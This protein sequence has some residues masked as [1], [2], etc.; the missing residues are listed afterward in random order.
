[1]ERANISNSGYNHALQDAER[2]GVKDILLDFLR[3]A[4]PWV[5][6]K[7]RFAG[8]LVPGKLL[9]PSPLMIR[10][11]SLARRAA[12][13]NKISGLRSLAGFWEWFDDW[14]NPHSWIDGF[15]TADGSEAPKT[16]NGS[17]RPAD[18]SP[19]R[20]ERAAA[21]PVLPSAQTNTLNEASEGIEWSEPLS[22]SE[23][24]KTFDVHYNTMIQWLR[25]GVILNRQVTPRRYRVAKSELPN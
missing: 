5:L 22:P 11:R 8:F 16:D 15:Q 18:A 13:E 7:M 9:A 24:A 20:A 4:D 21:T 23:L 25:K 6:G 2:I 1:L 19:Q 14:T 3:G 12:A 17:L 10:F